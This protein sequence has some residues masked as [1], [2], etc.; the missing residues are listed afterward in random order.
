MAPSGNSPPGHLETRP[1]HS[2]PSTRGKGT[3]SPESPRRV[4]SSERL[5]PQALM[6]MSTSPFCG[7]GM[8]QSS[9]LR[10][11]G[12]PGWRI[13]AARMVDILR[14]GTVGEERKLGI[15]EEGRLDNESGS[16]CV[17][18]RVRLLM[19]VLW[20]GGRYGLARWKKARVED[21]DERLD[22][23]CNPHVQEVQSPPFYVPSPRRIN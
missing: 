5:R 18:A 16:V 9:T 10:T 22:S 21:T 19:R 2:M 1:Q 17:I 8:G 15:I 13:T 4:N 14:Y 11:E 7:V 6:R 12:G 23:L 20:I 3:A